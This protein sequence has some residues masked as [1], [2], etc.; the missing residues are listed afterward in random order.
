MT[1]RCCSFSLRA[2][3]QIVVP[4][5][6]ALLLVAPTVAS[7]QVNSITTVASGLNFPRTLTIDGDNLYFGQINGPVGSLSVV[8]TTGG[9][10][11]DL[12]A[13]LSY[14]D[15]YGAYRG[16]NWIGFSATSVLFGWGSYDFY[17]IDHVNRDG[18]SRG[19]LV[20][21]FTGGN[22]IGLSGPY[23]YYSS[24][25]C[26]VSK[27]PSDG[28]A[29]P[30]QILN[31]RN[32]LQGP[33][34][35]ASALYFVDYY[36]KDLRRLD[37]STGVLTTLIGGTPP[38]QGYFIIDDTYLY[39]TAG[40]SII[41]LAKQGGAPTVLYTG[42]VD[43]LIQD[44]S[45]L[46]FRNKNTIFMIPKVGGTP[47]PL[48]TE[49]NLS[50][51]ASD[52]GSLFFTDGGSLFSE[53]ISNRAVSILS[54]PVSMS[55]AILN[56]GYLYWTDWSGGAGAGKILRVHVS[57]CSPPANQQQSSSVLVDYDARYEALANR[58]PNDYIICFDYSMKGLP[59]NLLSKTQVQELSLEEIAGSQIDVKFTEY[60]EKFR[61]DFYQPS[62]SSGLT[63]GHGIDLAEFKLGK[64]QLLKV[65]S[66]AVDDAISQG[67]WPTTAQSA[68]SWTDTIWFYVEASMMGEAAQYVGALDFAA[69]PGGLVVLRAIETATYTLELGHTISRWNK[70]AQISFDNLGADI[71]TFL[72]DVTFF[73]GSVPQKLL[74]D[75]HVGTWAA[76]VNDIA[77]K[78]LLDDLKSGNFQ[79]A[80]KDRSPLKAPPDRVWGW[81]QLIQ[82]TCSCKF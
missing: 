49:T 69:Q 33:V 81:V 39:F 9:R 18:T 24:G 37:L 8:P 57:T 29:L 65:L 52:G 7:G 13:G 1:N 62:A 5:F 27:V 35:D 70:G 15:G 68:A 2:I 46:Y 25:F 6:A 36:T 11:Q 80:V 42:E 75:L 55:E 38:T 64:T 41:K 79:A 21:P 67:T 72:F 53:S 54:Y 44:T 16:L 45:T 78:K 32:F 50:L 66:D 63:V 3:V 12:A 60:M 56:S 26:C 31:V 20:P 61:T 17:E 40:V 14:L 74:D 76:A 82:A 71:K 59:S 73:H 30:Q 34:L 47:T 19:V 4:F 10:V 77:P 23:T 43:S 51:I 28:S 48:Y 58:N 22:A